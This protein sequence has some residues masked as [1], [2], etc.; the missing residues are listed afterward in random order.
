[1]PA[2]RAYG[3]REASEVYS[4][5]ETELRRAVSAGLVR[6]RRKGKRGVLLSAD[7]LEREYG[8]GPPN[9]ASDSGPVDA[10][11]VDILAALADNRG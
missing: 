6:T 1:M 4:V 7:D 2:K 3:Y 11:A 10:V 5:G 8:F 9:L